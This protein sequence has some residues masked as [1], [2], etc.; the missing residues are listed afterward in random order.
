MMFLEVIKFELGYRLRQPLV[1]LLI[2][3]FFF[4][5]FGAM[6]TD[7]V[8]LGGAIGKVARNAPIVLSIWISVMSAIALL[9]VTA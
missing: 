4:M 1:Y 8:Q 3:A 2:V 9:V 7:S 5:A 6:S